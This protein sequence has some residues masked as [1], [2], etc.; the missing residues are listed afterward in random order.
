MPEGNRRKSENFLN[1]A[2][3][4]GGHSGKGGAVHGLRSPWISPTPRRV[5]SISGGRAAAGS[6]VSPLGYISSARRAGGF[7]TNGAPTRDGSDEV[8]GGGETRPRGRTEDTRVSVRPQVCRNGEW[9]EKFSYAS[10]ARYGNALFR[11]ITPDQLSR[12][13]DGPRTERGGMRQCVNASQRAPTVGF[14]FHWRV[15]DV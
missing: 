12:R 6:G 9:G 14:T 13:T 3:E 7:L 5:L 8:G 1:M 4:A 15:S 10:Y 2:A 11:W